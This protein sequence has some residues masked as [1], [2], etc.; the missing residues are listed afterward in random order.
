MFSDGFQ[1]NVPPNQLATNRG[2]DINGVISSDFNQAYVNGSINLSIQSDNQNINRVEYHDGP[3]IIGESTTFPYDFTAQNLSPGMHNMYAKLF[4]G[5]EFGIS[6]IINIQVGEQLPFQGNLNIIPGIIESG[7]YDNFEGGVGQGVS[8]LD[9]TQANN[10]G[11]RPG[12][13]VD[14]EYFAGEGATIGWIAAGEWTEYSIDV[15]EAGFYNLSVR[16][17]SGLS[18][19]HI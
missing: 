16:C 5:T 10:G 4:N 18:L 14:C 11:Y 12:E 8:Y 1:L 9:L 3:N 6:N 15:Q 17:A 19:I 13:Y 2:S 7:K